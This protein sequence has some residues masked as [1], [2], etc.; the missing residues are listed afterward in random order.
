MSTRRSSERSAF[1]VRCDTGPRSYADHRT[2]NVV[3]MAEVAKGERGTEAHGDI[4]A[5]CQERLERPVAGPEQLSLEGVHVGSTVRANSCSTSVSTSM[6]PASGKQADVLGQLRQLEPDG[7]RVCARQRASSRQPAPIRAA[8]CSGR[9]RSAGCPTTRAAI[10]ADLSRL[11][12]ARGRRR[13]A[14]W[15]QNAAARG[16]APG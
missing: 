14:C 11:M 12:P 9:G 6:R 13:R 3:H 7:S 2:W 16:D 5:T 8:A 1:R 15:R 4:L 10:R